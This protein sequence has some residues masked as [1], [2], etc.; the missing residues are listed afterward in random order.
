M[1]NNN[2]KTTFFKR[3]FTYIKGRGLFGLFMLD[4]A[5]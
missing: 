2:N 5:V 4:R 3:V 1:D